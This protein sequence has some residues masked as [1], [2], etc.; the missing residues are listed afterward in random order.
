MKLLNRLKT[1][2]NCLFG[3]HFAKDGLGLFYKSKCSV[4]YGDEIKHNWKIAIGDAEKL[5][6]CS[7][8]KIEEKISLAFDSKAFYDQISSKQSVLSE[9]K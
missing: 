5:L 7:K 9:V 3:R 2:R 8:V 6:G 4:Q 1:S